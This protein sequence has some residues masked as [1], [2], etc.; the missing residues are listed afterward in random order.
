MISYSEKS[1]EEV[2]Y[3]LTDNDMLVASQLAE[4]NPVVKK[5]LNAYTLTNDTVLKELNTAVMVGMRKLSE[6][7]KSGKLKRN[8]SYADAIVNLLS[9]MS[10]IAKGINELNEL[11]KGE[12][13]VVKKNTEP[14]T[15]YELAKDTGKTK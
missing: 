12:T 4:K 14:P 10:L 3:V 9:K 5:L 8:D 11:S 7:V 6:S 15:M 2:N 1:Y 13:T